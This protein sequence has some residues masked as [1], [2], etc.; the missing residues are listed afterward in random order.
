MEQ[1]IIIRQSNIDDA[2]S[3]Y[4][5][6]QK[7]FDISYKG[8]YPQ[9]A[10]DRFKN[11]YSEDFVIELATE[12]YT[13]VVEHNEEIIGTGNLHENSIRQV[14]IDP[15]YQKQG[16]GKLIVDELEL[17]AKDNQLSF[18]DLGA[19]LLS[20]NFWESLGYTLDKEDS[21]PIENDQELRFFRMSKNFI[22][23][24]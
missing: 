7:T 15:S 24:P 1:N 22:Y 12:G 16:V 13:V 6:L 8:V 19:S 10:I 11:R 21:V 9:E 3:I 23:N 17:K 4:G 2:A 14:Y 5:L 18:L 20:R